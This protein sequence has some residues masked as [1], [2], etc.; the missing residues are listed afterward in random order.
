MIASAGAGA[1][2][3]GLV[4]TSESN[5]FGLLVCRVHAQF[6]SPDD[7]LLAVYGISGAPVSVAAI[8]GTFYQNPFGSDLPPGHHLFAA[9]PS[10]EFDT[11]VT[12]GAAIQEEDSTFL[13]PG[14]PGFGPGELNVADGAWYLTPKDAPAVPD[15]QGR[16]LLAQ[17]STADGLGIE[18]HFIIE[19]IVG[20]QAVRI[21]ISFCHVFLDPCFGSGDLNG[22]FVVGTEDLLILLGCWGPVSG[23]ETPCVL[24]DEQGDA[25]GIVGTVDLLALLE[26]WTSIDPLPEV[27]ADFNDDGVV[28]LVDLFAMIG[29]QGTCEEFD[30][31]GDGVLDVEDLVLLLA[32]WG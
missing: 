4:L 16:V 21:P 25:N 14:W 6:T 19:A 9:F 17:F 13:A 31:D 26:D 5:G 7:R 11:F 15:A 18:G 32:N 8:G 30:L 3:D 27:D 24:A 1:S 20:E 22:D 10:L 12:I 29:C 28:N 23:R 2:F